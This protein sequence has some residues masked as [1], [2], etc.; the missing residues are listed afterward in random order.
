[1]FCVDLTQLHYFL[2]VA[3]CE[4]ISQAARRL[5]VSQPALSQSISK[6]EQTL[7]LRLFDRIHGHIRLTEAGRLLEA[8]ARRICGEADLAA[9]ELAR[10]REAMEGHIFVASA[11]IDV[12]VDIISEYM[13]RC[14]E[15]L[16]SY[17][18]ADR[19][20]ALDRLLGSQV[21][22]ALVPD[23]GE[24]ARIRAVP[25]YQDALFA[26]V[27][28]VHP[29]CR[30]SEVSLEELAAH[31]IGCNEFDCDAGSVRA[32][33]GNAGLTPDI[34]ADTN[35]SHILRKMI[36]CGKCAGICTSRAAVK[37]MERSADLRPLR[38]LP[39]RTRSVCLVTLAG[40]TLPPAAQKLCAYVEA[41][42]RRSGQEISQRIRTYYGGQP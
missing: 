12:F 41:Y 33:F 28:P 23:P 39:R 15:L 7:G 9:E 37:Y 34:A 6:L 25:L 42:C 1:M 21:E 32:L 22:F 17:H 24:D 11:V 16:I 4:S 2:A 30:R 14:P 5:Y 31:P 40:H 13:E 36:A 10:Y 3:E 38:I 19:Q 27:G 29:L 18:L 8:R 20:T 26:L 35:E